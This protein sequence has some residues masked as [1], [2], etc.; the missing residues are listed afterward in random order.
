[1]RYLKNNCVG[2]LSLLLVLL[3]AT[4]SAQVKIKGPTCVIPGALYHYSIEG[5]WD[6]LTRITICITG[7]KLEDGEIC[8]PRYNAI[9]DVFVVWD[10]AGDKSIQIQSTLI[11]TLLQITATQQLQGGVLDSASRVQ[12]YDSTITSYQFNCS[13]PIGGDCVAAYEFQWQMS[14]NTHDW[15]DIQGAT[16]SALSF[17]EKILV[18]TFFR[19][20][21]LE[22]NSNTI[23]Y[24][25]MGILAVRF[26][27]H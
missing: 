6:S 11:D 15:T 14:T 22:K 4:T 16:G 13:S 1:M 3:S 9:S 8:T 26:E 5:R 25:D 20:R 19:R 24:S 7:G 27:Q 10:D 17:S 12:E 21:L 23:T 18:N 2:I